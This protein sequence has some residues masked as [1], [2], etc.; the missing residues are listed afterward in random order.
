[1]ELPTGTVQSPTPPYRADQLSDDFMFGFDVE[2][3]DDKEYLTEVAVRGMGHED[4]IKSFIRLGLCRGVEEWE[5]AI[6]C[7]SAMKDRISPSYHPL[8]GQD[9]L[10]F[11]SKIYNVEGLGQATDDPFSSQRASEPCTKKTS[12]TN[13]VP[14]GAAIP[15]KAPVKKP[16]RAKKECDSPYWADPRDAARQEDDRKGDDVETKVKTDNSFTKCKDPLK[17]DT[18]SSATVPLKQYVYHTITQARGGPEPIASSMNAQESISQPRSDGTGETGKISTPTPSKGAKQQTTQDGSEALE[19]A[20]EPAQIGEWTYSNTTDQPPNDDDDEGKNPSA[21]PK[22]TPKRKTKSPYFATTINTTPRNPNPANAS[23]PP[24]HKRPPRGTIS[25]LPIP[26]LDAPRF[27]LIQEELATDPFQLLVAVTLLIKTSG[28]V[29]IPAFRA[30]VARYPTAEALAAAPE[31]DVLSLIAHLGL[32]AVRAAK[33]RRYARTW[34]VD[35]PRNGVRYVVKGYETHCVA[36]VSTTAITTTTTNAQTNEEEST[37][38][39]NTNTPILLY[40]TSSSSWEIGHLT[41]GPY[42]LDSW[43]IFCRDVLRGAATDWQGGGR[44]GTF[45]PEWMRVLPRDK[46]LRACLRWMWMRE[47]WL[48][49]PVTGDKVLLPQELRDAVQAGRVGYDDLGD[50]R[51]L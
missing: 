8:D 9:I 29:A 22:Q 43:R 12:K 32:G 16:R 42:A 34:L 17:T 15:L 20:F 31:A 35:P 2:N 47:G 40:S 49:D 10:T 33:I 38:D 6:S 13:G 27:G 44:E 25:S 3:D 26:P 51:I 7:A 36:D 1:M 48:W 39:T 4:D 50:L 23:P 28:R 18:T 14:Q 19:S 45:Q 37:P 21:S 5:Q 24:T 30:L 41:Q 46:E 11:L